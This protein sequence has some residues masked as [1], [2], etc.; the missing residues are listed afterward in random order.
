MLR[1]FCL[2]L[3]L[4]SLCLDAAAKTPVVPMPVARDLPVELVLDQHEIAVDVPATAAAVG[5]QFG[6]VGALIGSAVQNAQAKKAEERVVPLRNLLV[7]YRFNER[8]EEALR[9]KL[10]S[11][12]LSPNP[13]LTVR[14]TPWDAAEANAQPTVMQALVLTPRYAMSNDFKQ[15]SVTLSVSLV[16]RTR[17][18]NGKYKAKELFFRNYA[19]DFPM[20]AAQ[21]PEEQMVQRWSA[22]G[23]TGLASLLD[24]GVAQV[25]DLL[26]YD[27]SEAGRAEWGQTGKG[28]VTT[29]AGKGYAG[30]QVRQGEGWAWVRVGKGWAQTLQGHRPLDAAAIAALTAPAAVPSPVA[31]V[32]A[33]A[34]AP[35]E[36]VAP[37]AVGKG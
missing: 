35:V 15:M 11:A 7:E 4:A 33:P 32:Q 31:G 20:L 5:M 21:G 2:A 17:K 8:L 18:S 19:F 27:F 12:G 14:K 3:G 16:E 34:A 29:V 28:M 1:S 6:L 25:A 30:Q 10:A 23:S 13:Q 36:S 26:A 24:Q 9:A 37:A 22:L